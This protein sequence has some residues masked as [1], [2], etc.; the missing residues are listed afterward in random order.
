MHAPYGRYYE[1]NNT[2]THNY[3]TY[4]RDMQPSYQQPVIYTYGP[5]KYS[6]YY[7]PQNPSNISYVVQC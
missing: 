7:V 3:N 5:P 1:A 2:Y 4:N 6:S